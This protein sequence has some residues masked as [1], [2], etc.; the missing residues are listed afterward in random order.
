M[1]LSEAI[2]LALRAAWAAKLRSFF[3]VLGIVVSV[4]C[5]VIVVAIIQGRMLAKVGHD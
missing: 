2:R 1:P 5:F 3:T 4:G